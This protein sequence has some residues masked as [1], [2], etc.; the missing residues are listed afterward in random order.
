MGAKKLE[1]QS[2]SRG[3]MNSGPKIKFLGVLSTDV[4]FNQR[5]EVWVVIAWGEGVGKQGLRSGR[6]PSLELQMQI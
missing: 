3:G 5:L 1:D 4:L 2:S 6:E